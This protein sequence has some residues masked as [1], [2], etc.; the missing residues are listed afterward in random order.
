MVFETQLAVHEHAEEKGVKHGDGGGFGRSDQAAENAADDDDRHD[1][2][3]Q[4]FL[5]GQG[6]AAE[7]GA[8]GPFGVVPA[9]GNQA[10]YPQLLNRN[11]TRE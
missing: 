8:L 5:G 10:T 7:G 1:Q 2:G 9:L 3:Q 4:A 6:D 11:R